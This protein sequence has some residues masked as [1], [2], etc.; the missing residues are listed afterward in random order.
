MRFDHRGLE[1]VSDDAGPAEDPGSLI[2]ENLLLGRVG[3]GRSPVM[4]SS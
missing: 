2:A 1:E 3:M 4:L